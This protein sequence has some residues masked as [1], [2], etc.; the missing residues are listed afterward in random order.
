MQ[1]KLIVMGR[2]KAQERNQALELYLISKLTLKEVAAIVKVSEAQVG[3][4]A[5][6]DNWAVQRSARQTT[7]ATIIAN[8]YTMIAQIQEGAMTEKR[9]LTP[10][11]MHG[12]REMAG[13]IDKLN[14]KLNIG[15]YYMILEEFT[16][17][18]ML[19]DMSAA[20]VLAPH[21]REFLGKK[22]KQLENG[23]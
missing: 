2:T 11:E 16:K 14:K 22:V 18:L 20:K 3:K 5:K 9:L 10:A 12:I 19:I 21:I 6:A 1:E 23:A 4:W 8:H 17:E 7:A 13:T 15:N